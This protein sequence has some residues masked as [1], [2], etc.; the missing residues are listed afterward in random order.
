[1]KRFMPVLPTI[2]IWEWNSDDKKIGLDEGMREISGLDTDVFDPADFSPLIHPE[3]RLR[4]KLYFAQVFQAIA[5]IAIEYRLIRS[6]HLVISS[7][8]KFFPEPMTQ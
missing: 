7:E 3:D 4:T 6:P 1:M 8:P 5:P 2:G